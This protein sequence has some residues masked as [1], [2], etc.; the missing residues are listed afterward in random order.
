MS[1]TG[2]LNKH[3][4]RENGAKK[5]TIKIN[6]N[7]WRLVSITISCIS[8]YIW[9][10]CSHDKNTHISVCL[11]VQTRVSNASNIHLGKIDMLSGTTAKE[12]YT[13][14]TNQK[15]K[16]VIF[17]YDFFTWKS[18]NR[19]LNRGLYLIRYTWSPTV[20]SNGLKYMQHETWR[21]RMD[22]ILIIW[23]N[24]PNISCFILPN[25]FSNIGQYRSSITYLLNE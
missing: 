25:L 7:T 8:W 16:C 21:L 23:Y 24:M 2:L 6:A 19:Q 4:E 10:V 22:K 14:K 11:L 1:P 12:S 3:V 20:M 18:A 5:D 9:C 15:Q 17:W 13:I